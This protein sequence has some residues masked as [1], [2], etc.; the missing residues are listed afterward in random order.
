MKKSVAVLTAG[1]MSILSL[2]ITSVYAEAS[3]SSIKADSKCIYVDF[4]ESVTEASAVLKKL[5][6][7]STVECAAS[8]TDADSLAVSANLEL[9]TAYQLEITHDGAKSVKNFKLNAILN[10]DFSSYADTDAMLANWFACNGDGQEGTA[11]GIALANGTLV[12]D[13]IG[14]GIAPI[15]YPMQLY[16]GFTNKLPVLKDEYASINSFTVEYDAEILGPDNNGEPYADNGAAYFIYTAI[17]IQPNSYGR[18]YALPQWYGQ[19]MG[20]YTGTSTVVDVVDQA[21]TKGD[22]YKVKTVVDGKNADVNITVNE[23]T[24][25]TVS[26]VYTKNLYPYL[27]IRVAKSMKV[28]IDNVKLYT[29]TDLGEVPDSISVTGYE[30]KNPYLTEKVAKNKY[31]EVSFDA[32]IDVSAAN[33][34]NI[35]LTADGAIQSFT[36]AV[37]E[38]SKTLYIYMPEFEEWERDKV[39]VLS[40]NE[41]KDASGLRTTS[42]ERKF[43]FKTLL[44]DDF[45]YETDEE[46]RENWLTNDVDTVI[47]LVDIDEDTKGMNIPGFN[48][49]SAK[50]IY[51]Q[52]YHSQNDWKEYYFEYSFMVPQEKG[53]NVQGSGLRYAN[54]LTT[55][56]QSSTGIEYR[57]TNAI[58][59]RS[60]FDDPETSGQIFIDN[61][62]NKL[63]DLEWTSIN[64]GSGATS[65][66]SHVGNRLVPN[67]IYKMRFSFIDGVIETVYDRP[68][69]PNVA[70]D[71]PVGGRNGRIMEYKS[72]KFNRNLSGGIFFEAEHNMPI[73][74]SDV[75]VY[76]FEDITNIS[77]EDEQQSV[78]EITGVNTAEGKINTVNVKRLDNYDGDYV[79]IVALYNQDKALTDVKVIEKKDLPQLDALVVGNST[80]IEVNKDIAS[81][82]KYLKVFIWNGWTQIKPLSALYDLDL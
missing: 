10:D 71:T 61:N 67:E 77:D 27:T 59:V 53:M 56:L 8:M 21:F 18:S 44:A 14:S 42:F 13:G 11:Q 3:V 47:T 72:E 29:F 49:G 58:Y 30:V 19:K 24:K 50:I 80:D 45:N 40:L 70:T 74:I 51:P 79:L 12:I 68:N 65:Q 54:M 23:T 76:K 5:A 33:I 20:I 25:H 1:V 55:N 2:G 41:F 9:D 36:T 69:D 62:P 82:A 43:R 48:S 17:G 34:A 66:N 16:K 63:S 4:S 78:F 81:D 52:S 39:Y 46:L 37:S 64:I 15:V 32:A 28:A 38:D 75:K 57:R 73:Y 26:N 22:A 31:I 7:D 60:A 35:T 6:D